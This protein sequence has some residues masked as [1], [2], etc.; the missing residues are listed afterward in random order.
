MK[1]L[2]WTYVTMQGPISVLAPVIIYYDLCLNYNVISWKLTTACQTSLAISID[3]SRTNV[4]CQYS[5]NYVFNT[6]N[7]Y[8]YPVRSDKKLPKYIK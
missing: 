3:D 2:N 5:Y 7:K 8:Y 4:I 1:M 6:N